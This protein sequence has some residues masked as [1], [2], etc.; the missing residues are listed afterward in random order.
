MIIFAIL[1]VCY[2]A[3][4][5]QTLVAIAGIGL[6]VLIANMRHAD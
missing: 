5:T 3:Y 2:V 4:P 6:A 1:A